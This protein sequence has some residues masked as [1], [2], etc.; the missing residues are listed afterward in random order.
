MKY[1]IRGGDAKEGRNISVEG[2]I[3]LRSSELQECFSLCKKLR[4][5]LED[6]SYI[7]EEKLSGAFAEALKEVR[8]HQKEILEEILKEIYILKE[9]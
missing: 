7:P 6:A 3:Y 9:R 5:E 4:Q 2:G 8:K 1:L